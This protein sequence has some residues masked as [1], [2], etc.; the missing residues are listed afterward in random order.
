MRAI[1]F[2][3]VDAVVDKH[4]RDSY[5]KYISVKGYQNEVSYGSRIHTSGSIRRTRP[6]AKEQRERQLYLQ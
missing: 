3:K 6:R 1:P 2:Q 5:K 4:A